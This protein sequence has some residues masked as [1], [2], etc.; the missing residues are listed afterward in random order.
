MHG[1]LYSRVGAVHTYRRALLATVSLIY[2]KLYVLF[3]L[4][5]VLTNGCCLL[6]EYVPIA[7]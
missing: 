3:L 5:V 2:S 1:L 7:H 6:N 4:S